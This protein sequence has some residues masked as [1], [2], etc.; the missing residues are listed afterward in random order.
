MVY[1]HCL[2]FRENIW[3]PSELLGAHKAG[4][5]KIRG[6]SVKGKYLIDSLAHV[7][8]ESQGLILQAMYTVRTWSSSFK[9]NQECH[10]RPVEHQRKCGFSC[11]GLGRTPTGWT[12]PKLFG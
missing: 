5:L 7:K 11:D 2:L 6:N 1:F 12:L 8:P 10:D 9:E 3:Y 4:C